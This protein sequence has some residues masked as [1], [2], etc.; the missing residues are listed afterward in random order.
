MGLVMRG[1]VTLPSS[2]NLYLAPAAACLFAGCS[3]TFCLHNS[4]LDVMR[5]SACVGAACHQGGRGTPSRQAWSATKARVVLENRIFRSMFQSA[6]KFSIFGCVVYQTI[7][8]CVT[9]WMV[10]FRTKKAH[11]RFFF[12]CPSLGEFSLFNRNFYIVCIILTHFIPSLSS[13]GFA[14]RRFYPPSLR[15]PNAP[16]LTG[17][18]PNANVRLALLFP[19]GRIKLPCKQMEL[20]RLI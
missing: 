5:R 4:L 10:I 14:L 15:S 9:P 6:G 1:A 7:G 12:G 13:S 3:N 19:R 17:I 2:W 16:L 8:F 18:C 20:A 11:F